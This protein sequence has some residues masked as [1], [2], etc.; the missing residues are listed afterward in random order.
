MAEKIA[1][2]EMALI[3]E[4]LAEKRACGKAAPLALLALLGGAFAFCLAVASHRDHHLGKMEPEFIQASQGSWDVNGQNINSGNQAGRD[5]VNITKIYM[6]SDTASHMAPSDPYAPCT[7]KSTTRN[8]VT[9]VDGGFIQYHNVDKFEGTFVDKFFNEITDVKHLPRCL[10]KL[11]LVDKH[12]GGDVKDLPR[13][14]TNLSLP[15]QRHGAQL[16]GDVK[17][18]PRFLQYLDLS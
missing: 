12:L 14:L 18:L 1:D 13:L 3:R 5:I 6:T 9:F 17:Q 8:T 7:V 4:D 15:G 16:T 10:K 11:W 2:E